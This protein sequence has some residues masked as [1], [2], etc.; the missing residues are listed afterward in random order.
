MFLAGS[1]YWMNRASLTEFAV[2][3]RLA[4]GPYFPPRRQNESI[5]NDTVNLSLSLI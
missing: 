1:H 2:R 4:T 3:F 5:V